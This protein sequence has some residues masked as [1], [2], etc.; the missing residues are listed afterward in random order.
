MKLNSL[1][2]YE[3]GVGKVDLIPET[4]I[5]MSLPPSTSGYSNA[6][7]DDCHTLNRGEFRWRAPLRM[8]LR[9]RVSHQAP[10]GTLGFGFWNDP[11]TLSLGQRGAGR[12]FPAPPQTAWFFYGS[13]PNN[14][15]FTTGIPGHG[16]K[17]MVL[18]SPQIP[19]P[20]LLPAA[21]LGLALSRI[22]IIR[23][24]IVN[25]A[26]ASLK[27]AEAVMDVD[28]RAWHTY[29]ILWH[30]SELTFKVDGEVVLSTEVAPR[31]PLGFVTWMDN[32]YAVATGEDGLQFGVL[33]VGES[34]WLEAEGLTIE[35]LPTDSNSGSLE[36]RT[37]K[38]EEDDFGAS[39]D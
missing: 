27:T 7:L 38:T 4:G 8:Y 18:R 35:K 11:F 32:Q 39:D 20:L 15:S 34:Q 25:T 23:A 24:P 33:P 2:S 21:G 28:L 36:I 5:R 13:K 3:H 30:P 6:Q 16:W 17:A 12:R 22:P 9:A 19:S 37:A 1:T 14:L 10:Q 26:K 31:G 29:E